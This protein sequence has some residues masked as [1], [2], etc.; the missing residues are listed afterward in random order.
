MTSTLMMSRLSSI[1][2]TRRGLQI[3]LGLVWLLDAALQYQPYMFSRSFASQVLAPTAQGNPA[4][5]AQPVSWAATLTG[6]HVILANAAFATVQL[7]IAL[8]ILWR[9]TAPLALAASVPWALAVWWLG[10]GLGGVL[11]SSSS[12]VAGAPG[13]AIIYALL[14]VL[15]W[16]TGDKQ[17]G[18]RTS[19]RITDRQSGAPSTQGTD[20]ASAAARGR[21]S[22][23]ATGAASGALA[24]ASPAGRVASRLAWLALWGSLAYDCLLQAN[25]TPGGLASMT[26]GLGDGE[27]GWIA[28]IDSGASREL[29]GRG[30]TV[31]FVLA[32]VLAVIAAAI[33]FPAI[34]RPVLVIAVALALLIWVAGQ[35]FGGILTGSGTDPNSGP[36]LVLLALAY[37]PRRAAS[38]HHATVGARRHGLPRS[39]RVLDEPA[40]AGTQ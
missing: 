32:L 39:A 9:R 30:D 27:P 38:R 16:P 33:F 1:R 15:L 34:C 19:G 4:W 25:R 29:A 8:G 12:A 22:G 36:V 6:H 2:I 23:L 3:A 13:A 28:A 14:A 5:V 26:A 35:D 31:S 11:T 37:W 10:E 40:S 20:R 21:A 18:G 24:Y 17:A 7:A